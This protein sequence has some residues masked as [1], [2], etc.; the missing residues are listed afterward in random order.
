MAAYKQEE[1]AARGRLA[2]LV[3]VVVYTATGAPE[4]KI[5][6]DLDAFL[7]YNLAV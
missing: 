7:G 3:G 6:G 1:S 4:E 5:A 2:A